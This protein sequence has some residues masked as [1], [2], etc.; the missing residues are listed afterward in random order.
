MRPH[1]GRATLTD[2]LVRRGV[3]PGEAAR[4]AA[5]AAG[6]PGRALAGEDG[7]G[8]EGAALLDALP[9]AD[10]AL[11]L[12]LAEGFRGAPGAERFGALLDD[13]GRS[14]HDRLAAA[15]AGD[16]AG[17]DRWAAAWER[18]TR[19]A[20]EAEALNLD[21]ADAFFSLVAELSAAARLR[22]LSG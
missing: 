7:S 19:G 12:K 4:R 5:A 20:G 18:V 15:A 1:G 11:L 22:P 3:P 21:R 9:A 6:S 17:L 13:L 10:P 8:G 14:L 16:P 2:W